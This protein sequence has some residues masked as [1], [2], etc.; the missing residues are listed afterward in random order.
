MLTLILLPIKKHTDNRGYSKFLPFENSLI[1]AIHFCILKNK[2]SSCL[3][4][5]VE[6][7]CANER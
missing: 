4:S 2:E 7:Y 1:I 6:L 5:Y 3:V